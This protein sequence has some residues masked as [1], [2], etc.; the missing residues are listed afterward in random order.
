[1]ERGLELQDNSSLIDNL[2][3]IRPLD[4]GSKSV[5]NLC[6]SR[7]SRG[8]LFE[9]QFV[10]DHQE[11]PCYRTPCGRVRMLAL[12]AGGT[13]NQAC[14]RRDVD[15]RSSLAGHTSGLDRVCGLQQ[16]PE[17]RVRRCGLCA[18]RKERE[19]GLC[20]EEDKEEGCPQDGIGRQGLRRTP[21]RVQE[22]KEDEIAAV[23]RELRQ[24]SVHCGTGMGRTALDSRRGFGLYVQCDELSQ[25]EYQQDLRETR[26]SHIQGGTVLRISCAPSDLHP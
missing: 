20:H 16:V 13:H 25:R 15:K 21:Q 12:R 5:R 4:D 19:C 2:F 7:P 9:G 23:H 10:G 18:G 26:H 24:I 6:I 17:S 1:V 11:C 14:Q 22:Q 3:R 8:L